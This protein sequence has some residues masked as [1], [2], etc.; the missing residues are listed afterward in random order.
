MTQSVAVIILPKTKDSWDM[1]D[2]RVISTSDA[3]CGY[4]ARHQNFF[5]YE[6]RS[7]CISKKKSWFYLNFSTCILISLL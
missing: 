1:G 4:H 5:P 7:V 6:L 3:L 2:I